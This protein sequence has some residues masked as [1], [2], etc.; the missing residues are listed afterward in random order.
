MRSRPA[1]T[2]GA[3]LE[4]DRVSELLVAETLEQVIEWHEEGLLPKWATLTED[5][6]CRFVHADIFALAR[7]EAGFDER[8]AGRRFD[9]ILVDIDHTP[10]HVL[11]ASHTVLYTE[12]G[13]R[14]LARYLTADGVSGLWSDDPPTWR[15][16]TSLSGCSATCGPRWSSSATS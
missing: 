12:A 4:D 10:S 5:G 13:L 6:R 7:G 9:A 3:V 16:C 2:A 14:R 15:S 11:D 1:G 8:Q